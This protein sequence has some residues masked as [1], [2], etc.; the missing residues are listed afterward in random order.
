MSHASSSA[1]SPEPYAGAVVVAGGTGRRMGGGPGATPKQ[2]LE[3]EGEPVLRYALSPFLAHPAV[4]RVVLVLPEADALTPPSWLRGIGVKI[5]AGG[6]ERAD[7]VWNGLQAL[8]R[9]EEV[10]VVLVHDGARPLADLDLIDRVLAVARH[11]GAVPALPATDTIKEADAELRVLA[12]ADRSRLWHAQTPQGFPRELLVAAYRRARNEGW[13]VTDDAAVF[14]RCGHP[15][16]LVEG[17]PENIKITRPLDLEI[18]R[19]L[20]RRSRA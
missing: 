6:P 17:S 5:V 12:T 3:I 1:S 18:A 15:V 13:T 11:E 19:L 7:S 10:E 20:A 8:R 16:R 9:Y 14:E 4:A 2:Y